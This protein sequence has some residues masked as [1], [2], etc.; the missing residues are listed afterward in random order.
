M[1]PL[2]PA[3]T[4]SDI[5]GGEITFELKKAGAMNQAER[6][7]LE[8]KLVHKFN[9]PSLAKI[10]FPTTATLSLK[11]GAPASICAGGS[12]TLVINIV[13]ATGP[14]EVVYSKNGTPQTPVSGY[15]SGTDIP[16]MPS[17]TA[18]YSI[19][20]VS[21]AGGCATTTNTGNLSVTVRPNPTI[22]SVIPSATPVCEGTSVG[23]TA[24]GLLP[25]V[26]TDFN[27]AITP[28]GPGSYTATT[29]AS[30]NVSFAPAVYPV[31]TYGITINSATVDGCTTTFSSG[32]TT[33]F[34]VN[35]TPTVI[36]RFSSNSLFRQYGNNQFSRIDGKQYV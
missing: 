24:T 23:F 22:S 15:V 25:S 14:F 19:V 26:S 3:S 17:E 5:D 32:N 27:Y 11:A 7:G 12:S 6:E 10:C 30:G 16:I 29:D 18:T 31:G 1:D 36:E 2:Y 13:S 35:P 20:S 4:N 8:D 21:D 28:G 33:S 9:D 34:K